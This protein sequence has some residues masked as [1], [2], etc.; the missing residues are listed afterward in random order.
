MTR[1]PSARGS[2]GLSPGTGHVVTAKPKKARGGNPEKRQRKIFKKFMAT[3]TVSRKAQREFDYWIDRFWPYL[4]DG[5]TVEDLD[6]AAA[7]INT[8]AKRAAMEN[9][10][11]VIAKGLE[12]IRQHGAPRNIQD[13]VDYVRQ[14]GGMTRALKKDPL[15][16][17]GGVLRTDRSAR[18]LLGRVFGIKG[19]PGRKPRK[20]A[21]K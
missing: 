1:K 5:K 16:N 19:N 6:R 12:Y 8:P 10:R 21:P 4:D 11:P 20:L 2:A 13:L 14:N 15:R 9:Q 7:E 18:N 17:R 3:N